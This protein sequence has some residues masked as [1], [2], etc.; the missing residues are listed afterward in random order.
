MS[1]TTGTAPADGLER[2]RAGLAAVVGKTVEVVPRSEWSLRPGGKPT[3][4]PGPLPPHLGF[5][6]SPGYASAVASGGS[7]ADVA[8]IHYLREDEHS[9]PESRTKTYSHVVIEDLVSHALWPNVLRAAGL[10]TSEELEVTVRAHVFTYSEYRKD[11]HW[12][13]VPEDIAQAK[14]LDDAP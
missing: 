7:H 11:H 12:P 9:P 14:P 2:V 10:A 3:V 5:Q 1:A 6:G 13:T 8:G 4:L